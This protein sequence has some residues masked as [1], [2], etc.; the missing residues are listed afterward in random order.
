MPTPRGESP[1]LRAYVV[2][3]TVSHL[4]ERQMNRAAG[5]ALPTARK[6]ARR[7]RCLHRPPVRRGLLLLTVAA[8]SAAAVLGALLRR[9]RGGSALLLLRAAASLGALGVR[10]RGATG[11][12][13]ALL[14]GGRRGLRRL[15]GGTA[16]GEG[17]QGQGADNRRKSLR[18]HGVA[19]FRCCVEGELRCGLRGAPAP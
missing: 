9:R 15:G 1:C 4:P 16:G 18:V 3:T 8:A 2:A 14:R 10:L 7:G 12:L 17:G 6:P 19:S 5:G 11:A 13:G